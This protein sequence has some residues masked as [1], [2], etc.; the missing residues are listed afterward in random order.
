MGLLSFKEQNAE[1]EVT[2]EDTDSQS[3]NL[4]D[5]NE[6]ECGEEVQKK[7]LPFKNPNFVVSNRP[8]R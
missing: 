8:I 4:E 6:D 1:I 2:K 7:K 5:N 3:I